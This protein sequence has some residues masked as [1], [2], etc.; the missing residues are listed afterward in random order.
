MSAAADGQGDLIVGRGSAGF[1]NDLFFIT[2][3]H[4]Q[5]EVA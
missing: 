3:F 5:E 1:E 4:H 2:G